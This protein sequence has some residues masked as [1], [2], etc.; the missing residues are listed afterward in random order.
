MSGLNPGDPLTAH[1]FTIQID[2]ITCAWFSQISGLG[3]SVEV[4]SHVQNNQQGQPKMSMGPGISKGG[5]VTLTRGSDMTEDFSNWVEEGVN[6]NMSVARKN[7][8]VIYMDY[9][10]NPI[11]R[12]NLL[13]AWACEHKYGDLEAGSNSPVN[14]TITITYEDIK[15]V[16]G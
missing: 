7:I 8:S 9:T 14:E 1:N 6:G 3:K 4:I 11:K 16:K 15:E 10:G 5:T 12:Y 13:N 2:G